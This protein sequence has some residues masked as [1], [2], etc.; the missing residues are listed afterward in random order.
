MTKV[1]KGC[2]L[3]WDLRH[4]SAQLG[5]TYGDF[6]SSASCIMVVQSRTPKTI[7]T[8]LNQLRHAYFPSWNF[9]GR[10]CQCRREMA[11][12]E[13]FICTGTHVLSYVVRMTDMSLSGRSQLNPTLSDEGWLGLEMMHPSTMSCIGLHTMLNNGLVSTIR[14]LSFSGCQLMLLAVCIIRASCGRSS[15]SNH[16]IGRWWVCLLSPKH[17]WDTRSSPAGSKIRG[18]HSA[19][20]IVCSYEE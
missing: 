3:I 12:N 1:G 8:G 19:R 18:S 14:T 2:K 4:A 15:A 6:R 17:R 9:E 11:A 7:R 20:L 5:M 10:H 13:G 16:S